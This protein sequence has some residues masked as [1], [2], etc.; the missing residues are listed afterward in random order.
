MTVRRRPD[1]PSGRPVLR[2]AAAGLGAAMAAVVLAGCSIFPGSS[3][4]QTDADGNPLPESSAEGYAELPLY[5]VALNGQFPPN[6][7]GHL[8]ACEDLL[9]RAASA[10]VKTE[11]PV[12]SSIGFLLEDEQYDHGDPALTNSLDPS[13]DGLRYVSQRVEGDT[14][15]LELSG[16]VVTRSPCESYRIRAQLNRTAAEAAGVPHAEILVDGVRLEDLLAI[17]E[18][19]LGE[20][21]TTPPSDAGAADG[22]PAD[23]GSPDG[24]GTREDPA[25]TATAAPAPGA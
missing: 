7:T 4:A 19:E 13:D 24:S 23:T 9:V 16:D 12:A 1:R 5:F 20:E 15:V 14:V 17:S 25:G 11:D 8:V 18:L 3:D 21:I 22:A 6:T 2:R 10:P